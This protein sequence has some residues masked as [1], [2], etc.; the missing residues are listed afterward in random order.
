MQSRKL[1]VEG[2][3]EFQPQIFVDERG[4]FV[5]PFQES[6]FTDALGH[7]L[8]P[9]A[10]T[11]HSRSR[12]GVVRGAHYS[13]TPPGVAKH[14]YCSRG[15]A[16]DII[17]DVRTGSPTFGR[18]DTVLLDQEDF[19]AIYF[20]IGVAHAFIA[21]EDNTVMSYLLSGEYVK[22]NELALSVFDPELGL[23]IP[24]DIVPILSERDRAA[25]TLAQVQVEGTLPDYAECLK[26]ERALHSA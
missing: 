3:F 12:R 1:A 13:V 2:A 22:E 6:A 24:D 19:R 21:L 7:R 5:S 26:V 16:I 14:V 18:W 9:V 8:F 11:N 17:I 10:Q 25:P 20:P 4:I 23:P 15:K